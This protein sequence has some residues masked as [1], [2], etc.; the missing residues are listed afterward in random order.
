MVFQKLDEAGFH[1]KPSK[2]KFFKD[3]LEYLGHIISSQGI[4]TNPKKVVTIVNWPQPKNIMQI[5]SFLSFCNYYEKFI[6]GYAQ[7]AKP[8]YQLITGENAKKKAN[9]VEWTEKCEVAFCKLKEIC[10]DT[11]ILANADYTKSFKVHTDVSEQGLG[12]VLIKTRMMAPQ[13]S[14]HMQVETCQN[15]RKD[16]ILL[17]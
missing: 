1:L 15:Q 9:E 7:V 8:L 13:G 4:E 12:T 16:T 14:S 6:K 10:S 2:C 5:R 17:N 3:R 11:P